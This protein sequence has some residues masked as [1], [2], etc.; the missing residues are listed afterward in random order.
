MLQPGEQSTPKLSLHV[1]YNFDGPENSGS[2][3]THKGG[4]ADLLCIILY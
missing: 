1:A 4:Y 2:T 3:L